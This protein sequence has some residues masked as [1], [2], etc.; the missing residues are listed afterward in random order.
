M[1]AFNLHIANV[2]WGKEGKRRPVLILSQKGD[3]VAVFKITT[4][5][6][7]KSEAIRSN[8]FAIN[9]WKESGLNKPSFIDVGEVV[10]VSLALIGTRPIGKL[11]NHDKIRL[12]KFLAGHIGTASRK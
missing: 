1:D 2:S 4:Q 6:Q 7:S 9:D 3:T 12:E 10:G 5:Y 8:F 11:S